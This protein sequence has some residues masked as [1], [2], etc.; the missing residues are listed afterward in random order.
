MKRPSAVTILLIASIALGS[1]VSLMLW[2]RMQQT[3]LERSSSETVIEVT[4]ALAQSWDAQALVG[5]ASTRMLEQNAPQVLLDYYRHQERHGELLSIDSI[6]GEIRNPPVWR[7]HATPSAR[8]VMMLQFRWGAAR[9][10]TGLSYR[11]GRWEFDHYY[12][13]SSLNT[14]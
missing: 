7:V 14:L 6:E 9:V 4:R 8:Y 5:R 10:E 12:L 1:V 2:Q 3:R 13:F 11:D